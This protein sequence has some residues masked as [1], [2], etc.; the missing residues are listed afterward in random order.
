MEQAQET[1][2][3]R[4]HHI[5][6]DD[7]LLLFA[8]KKETVSVAYVLDNGPEFD[9][10]SCADPLEPEYDGGSQS[11]AVF[12]WNEGQNP[13]IYSQAHGGIKYRFRRYGAEEPVDYD[14][15]LPELIQQTKEDCGA[16]FAEDALKMLARLKQEDKGRFMRTRGELKAANRAVLLKELDR[17]INSV[18]PVRKSFQSSSPSSSS[19]SISYPS[20]PPSLKEKLLHLQGV[21]IVETKKGDRPAPES[22][23]AA[24]FAETLQGLCWY[25]FD[26]YC[27]RKCSASEFD[28]VLNA[29]LYSATDGLGF[30]NNYQT[31]I[32]QILQKN[33]WNPLPDPL[34]GTIPFQNGLLDQNTG[35]LVPVTA[36]NAHT[37]ALPYEYSPDADCP[38]FLA[39]LEA[40]LDNDRE[41]VRLL[42]AWFNALLTGRPDLQ[43]FIPLLS[44]PADTR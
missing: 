5:L 25:R 17:D 33:G 44:N 13:L 27:W 6:V 8:H 21:L 35:E 22:K 41:S 4:Q 34:P 29:L 39:W 36:E 28:S 1:V 31:G 38:H 32:S 11:K 42:Q 40:A 19:Y 7:D 3:A 24:L 14:T 43:V 9:N 20:Y 23:A 30:S 18:L 37:W 16:P 2:K 26:E 15:A 10:K 12:Y